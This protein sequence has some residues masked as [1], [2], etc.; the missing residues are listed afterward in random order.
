MIETG[1]LVIASVPMSFYMI[2]PHRMILPH[3]LRRSLQMKAP[4]TPRDN[5]LQ[6]GVQLLLIRSWADPD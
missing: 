6:T 5:R 4:L 3:F 1:L 2:L